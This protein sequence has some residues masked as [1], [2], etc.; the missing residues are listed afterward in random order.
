MSSTKNH[1]QAIQAIIEAHKT[2][3]RMREILL[4]ILAD[5]PSAIVNAWEKVNIDPRMSK[6]I[7]QG[8][9]N[10][11]SIYLFNGLCKTCHE[12]KQF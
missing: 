7:C 4:Q 2:K 12:A 3:G 11:Y 9:P 1:K 6:G 10:P 5:Q 8:C